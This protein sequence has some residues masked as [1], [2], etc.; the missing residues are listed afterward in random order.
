MGQHTGAAGAAAEMDAGAG[1]GAGTV[2]D[3]PVE[4][5]SSSVES[6]EQAPEMGPHTPSFVAAAELVGDVPAS[7]LVCTAEGTSGYAPQRLPSSQWRQVL[8]SSSFDPVVSTGSG[9]AVAVAAAS[10]AGES[11]PAVAGEPRE[12]S[13]RA[14]A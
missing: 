10:S 2:A 1:A 4:A 9:P 7:E 11:S 12:G 3:A 6:P 5:S 8:Q 13:I 14:G